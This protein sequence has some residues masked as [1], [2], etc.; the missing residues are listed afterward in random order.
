MGSEDD[1]SER[2]PTQ[3]HE[4]PC[5]EGCVLVGVRGCQSRSRDD[6]QEER[7]LSVESSDEESLAPLDAGS[8][9]VA[10]AVDSIEGV[11][12]T[13]W[14]SSASS[15]GSAELMDERSGSPKL[16]HAEMVSG[17]CPWDPPADLFFCFFLSDGKKR[18]QPVHV[19]TLR[20][21]EWKSH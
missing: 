5:S 1:V 7:V 20:V 15:R 3:V 9:A 2:F 18:S 16:G 6:P 21:T 4:R 12:P 10:T 17:S 19:K 14:E 11:G 13:Q 8:Q